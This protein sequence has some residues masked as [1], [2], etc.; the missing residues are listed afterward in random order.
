M[1]DVFALCR[2]I[3]D[4]CD[5]APLPVVL[6]ALTVQLAYVLTQLRDERQDAIAEETF[7]QIRQVL[8]NAR[9]GPDDA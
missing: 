7:E 6:H 8:R 1:A 2:Q 4:V 5:N 9:G 3:G